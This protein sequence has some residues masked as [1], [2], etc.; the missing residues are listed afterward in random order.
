VSPSFPID[1]QS[2][3]RTRRLTLARRN[4]LAATT[5]SAPCGACTSCSA[6]T[7]SDR[8]YDC[9][10]SLT[11]ARRSFTRHPGGVPVGVLGNCSGRYSHRGVSQMA[12]DFF[13]KN[14]SDAR[15]SYA[16]V[17]VTVFAVRVLLVASRRRGC[18]R[19]RR[20]VQGRVRRRGAQRRCW[21]IV[22][23]GLLSASSSTFRVR[24]LSV[25]LRFG[26]S[27][28][29]SIFQDRCIDTPPLVDAPT[30]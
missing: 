1:R 12:I 3:P 2:L 4:G 26:F 5:P 15:T 18:V 19:D 9:T 22:A 27:M 24:T 30:L 13:H 21:S 28:M 25:R 7:H 8:I 6:A 29:T 14:D 20:R 11:A 23:D 16:W 10:A 17:E